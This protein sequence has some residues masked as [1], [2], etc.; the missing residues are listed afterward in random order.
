[1]S[2][3]A[4]SATG[5]GKRYELGVARSGM[6]S[7]RLGELLRGG[8]R[9]RKRSEQAS[10]E[11]WA[12]RDVA[13]EIATGE[14][15]GLLGRNG[16]GKSTLLKLIARIT[17]PTEGRASVRGRVGTLLEVG[18][19]FH[20]ELSGRENV[21]LNGAV[22]GMK[23]REI[24]RK[25]DE[26]VEFAGVERFLET[27]VKRYSSGMYVRLAFAVAAHLEPEIL[28]VDE[29]L[30]VGDVEF[31]RKCLGKMRDVASHGRTVLF[32]SHNVGAIRR[33]CERALLFEDGRLTAEGPT[34]DVI[35]RYMA[36]AV[37]DQTPGLCEVA[38]DAP[39]TG[40]G[41]AR[42]RRLSLSTLDGRPL[43]AL[44]LDERFRVSAEFEVLA[45]LDDAVVEV[46]VSTFAGD[47]VV[48]ANSVDRERPALSFEPGRREIA[49]ELDPSM[50]PGEFVIDLAI[51]RRNGSTVDFVQNALRFTALNAAE[52]GGDHY[53]WNAV[54]GYV[55]PRALW[56]DV[57]EVSAAEPP[58]SPSSLT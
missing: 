2:D 10:R 3:L 53:P 7:E 1:V 30:A 49:V 6:L 39:R 58:A 15:V 41:E 54:R 19:G 40:T 27:P 36:S 48:T 50:L 13:F 42:L 18:T 5:L 29:V 37:P 23:R 9:G 4:I 35:A 26:I 57:R 16:A 34:G 28:L 33:L 56:S 44:H 11:F 14:V 20:P 46:G 47:R 45:A 22:L 31:Q 8:G 32:V 12:L 24:M 55:R 38:D 17:S 52:E 21:F 43:S 51:H 25:Y